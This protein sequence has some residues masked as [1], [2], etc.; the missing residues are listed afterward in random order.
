M[1]SPCCVDPQVLHTVTASSHIIT[2]SAAAAYNGMSAGN[3]ELCQA[4]YGVCLVY[5]ACREGGYLKSDS[6]HL[7]MFIGSSESHTG[8]IRLNRL[9]HILFTFLMKIDVQV[10]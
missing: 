4:G 5:Y 9:H 1:L 7:R 10:Y 8:T 2:L 6:P 3:C